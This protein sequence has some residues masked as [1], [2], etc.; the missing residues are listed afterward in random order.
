M[1]CCSLCPGTL[2]RG[3]S[4]R[5]RHPQAGERC[6]GGASALGPEHPGF[7]PGAP[8]RADGLPLSRRL[9]LPTLRWQLPACQDPA[10]E[11]Q[12][13]EEVLAVGWATAPALDGTSLSPRRCRAEP[14]RVSPGSV[15][16]SQLEAGSSPWRGPCC[17]LG[18]SGGGWL[19]GD[20]SALLCSSLPQE[21][22][23]GALPKAPQSSLMPAATSCCPQACAQLAARDLDLQL[24]REG[25]LRAGRPPQL[26]QELRD[27]AFERYL[28]ILYGQQ[29][30]V[31]VPPR[32]AGA[33]W[34]RTQQSRGVQQAAAWGGGSGCCSMGWGSS[35]S[36]H[37]TPTAP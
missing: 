22:V 15:P 10:R 12:E 17:T 3:C 33:G 8:S 21:L 7:A 26:S 1:P 13:M 4:W 29:L 35:A 28:Q 14:R 24:L 6:S 36:Q 16:P 31:Q 11:Q 2:Q 19:R 18:C 34:A 25:K 30:R 5:P 23:P 20:H 27:E 32:R 9:R 37:W